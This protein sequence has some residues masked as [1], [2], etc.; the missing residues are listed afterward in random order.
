M[1]PEQNTKN[2]KTVSGWLYRFMENHAIWF[3]VIFSTVTVLVLYKAF[4]VTFLEKTPYMWDYTF[5]HITLTLLC[6]LMMREAYQGEFHMGFHGKR[7]GL[8]LLL[9][10]PARRFIALN[11]LSTLSVG[12]IYP[13]SLIMEMAINVSVGLFEEV[14]VRAILVGHMMHYWKNSPHRVFK[15]VLWSSVLFGV[16]HIGNVFAN[17]VGTALQIFYAAGFG[18]M[19]AAAYIRTRNLW[20]CILVHALVD[21]AANLNSIYVP[22]Q[23]DMEAYQM[24]LRELPPLVYSLV[25]Q[26]IVSILSGIFVPGILVGVIFAVAA[27]AFSLR[28]SKAEE[29]AQL[30]ENM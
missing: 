14:V 3:W 26:Q 7:F 19:F 29:I 27:G 15:S 20:S 24:S 30:W 1:K 12:R 17:P 4:S 22:L 6:I 28:K 11:L 10:W 5:H 23:A 21:L 13:E 18:V 9:C 2:R 25:P 16:L 8:G